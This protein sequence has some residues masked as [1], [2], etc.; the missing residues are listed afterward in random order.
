MSSIIL[1][2]GF[3]PQGFLFD[4]DGV[5]VDSEP[6]KFLALQR[7][8]FYL[9]GR[10]EVTEDQRF[11][12]WYYGR[13][14]MSGEET[15]KEAVQ[16]FKLEV[17]PNELYRGNN[18]LNAQRAKMLDSEPAIYIRDTREF[19][20]QIPKDIPIGVAS[21]D[22]HTYI[23]RHLSETGLEERIKCR[24]SGA[25]TEGD[26]PIGGDKPEPHAYLEL[27]RKMKV[28]PLDCIGVEDTWQGAT[29]LRRAGVFTIVRI[30]PL[31]GK[32]D[33]SSLSDAHKPHIITKSL[34]EYGFK[35]VLEEYNIYISGRD[36][37]LPFG[38]WGFE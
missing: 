25:K 18:G 5:I 10:K 12:D 23:E 16:R 4:K 14:G 2:Q 9:T 38:W 20:S 37:K 36:K 29:A 30:N 6:S 31:S 21:S 19:I 11:Y 34:S 35:R 15:C 26:V 28:N 32:F 3:L 7:A 22:Y 24:V 1:P 17:D 33:F 8:V 13:V 27:A